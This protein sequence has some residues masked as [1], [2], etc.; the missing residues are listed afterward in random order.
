MISIHAFEVTGSTSAGTV[1][2]GRLSVRS[3]ACSGE[4]RTDIKELLVFR[5]SV[6]GAVRSVTSICFD[7]P[8]MSA[9][10]HWAAICVWLTCVGLKPIGRLISR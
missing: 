7:G 2:G 5:R 8:R 6:W 1:S 4:C 10:G 9:A 3:T